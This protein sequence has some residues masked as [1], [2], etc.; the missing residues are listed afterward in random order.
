MD[1]MDGMDRM[2]RMG[3]MEGMEGMDLM[4]GMDEVTKWSVSSSHHRIM[5]SFLHSWPGLPMRGSLI[6]S[7]SLISITRQ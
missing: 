7:L 5:P 1:G 2:D 3:G 6:R 4:E